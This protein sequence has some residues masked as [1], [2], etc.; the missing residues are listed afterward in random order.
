MPSQG[1]FHTFRNVL[2]K[3]EHVQAEETYLF[4]SLMDVVKHLSKQDLGVT[5]K[6]LLAISVFHGKLEIVI[7]ILRHSS[8]NGG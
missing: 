2:M 6:C 7:V 1:F 5:T 3:L 8:D 4:S